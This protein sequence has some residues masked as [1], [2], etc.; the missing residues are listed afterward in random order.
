MQEQELKHPVQINLSSVIA[1]TRGFLKMLFK[2][3]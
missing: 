1:L 3:S 2:V